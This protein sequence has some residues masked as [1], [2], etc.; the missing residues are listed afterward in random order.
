MPGTYRKSEV[1]GGLA[2]SFTLLT[3]ATIGPAVAAG[4]TATGLFAFFV[5]D[6]HPTALLWTALFGGVAMGL[7][8]IPGQYAWR[9]AFRHR[10]LDPLR[11]LGGVMTDAGRG[12]LT[13]RGLH[14]RDDEIGV[15]VNECNGLIGSLAGIAEQVRHS[16]ES[17]SN[18]ATQLSASSEEINAS[19]MEISSSVQQIAHGAE[20]QSRKVEETSSAME[21]ITR[22]V[23]DVARRAEEASKTSEEVAKAAVLGEE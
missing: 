2:W 8:A 16:A 5:L 19:S 3:W 21:S 20:P 4:L 12:D 6:I 15:L 18:A 22:T 14:D 11:D 17:V 23:G 1:R 10:V 7:C 9:R 13:V